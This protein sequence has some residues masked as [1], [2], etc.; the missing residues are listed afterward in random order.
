MMEQKKTI[1]HY[2]GQVFTTYGI[3]ISIF[4]VFTSLIGESASE[5]STLY[6]LGNKGLSMETLTQLLLLSMVTTV[7]QVVFLTDQWVKTMT[8]F[9]RNLLF[10]GTM[11]VILICFIFIFSWFPVNNGKAWICFLLSFL[12]C[13]GISVGISKWEEHIENKKMEQALKKMKSGK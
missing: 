9:V 3:I 4:L 13:T 12:V 11:C 6:S 1:F 10:F 8:M 5:F 7:A 2:I